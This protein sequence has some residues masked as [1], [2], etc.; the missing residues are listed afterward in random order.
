[1]A[2][3]RTGSALSVLHLVDWLPHQG[4][5]QRGCGVERRQQYTVTSLTPPSALPRCQAQAERYV[6]D[7]AALAAP[8][9]RP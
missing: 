3:A 5:Q 9:I 6:R 1:M 2:A 7:A 4:S 8:G